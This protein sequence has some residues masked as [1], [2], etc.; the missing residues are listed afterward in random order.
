MEIED[1]KTKEKEDLE[2]ELEQASIDWDAPVPGETDEDREYVKF[3]YEQLMRENR[4]ETTTHEDPRK[5]SDTAELDF[6]ANTIWPMVMESPKLHPLVKEH[7][8]V[9][10]ITMILSLCQTLTNTPIRYDEDDSDT[11]SG[12]N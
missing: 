8:L 12:D 11:T 1:P 7:L 3:K 5:F 2:W 6:I 9:S 4:M 10:D